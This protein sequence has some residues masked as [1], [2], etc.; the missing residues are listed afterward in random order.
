MNQ[1]IFVQTLA[2]RTRVRAVG[3]SIREENL[4]FCTI[5]CRPFCVAVP[6]GYASPL[7]IFLLMWDA[8]RKSFI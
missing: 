7:Q 8:P 4:G 2:G 6:E 5:N 1:R 3:I